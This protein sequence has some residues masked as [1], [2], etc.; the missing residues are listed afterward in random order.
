M[1]SQGK[2]KEQRKV[3]G[4]KTSSAEN[5]NNS[6]ESLPANWIPPLKVVW[7][8]VGFLGPAEVLTVGGFQKKSP[9]L[10]SLSLEGRGRV[11]VNDSFPHHFL[12]YGG[13][14]KIFSFSPHCP[15]VEMVPRL[16]HGFFPQ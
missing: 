11:R 2:Q 5:L 6:R 12:L 10:I 15:Q 1:E 16:L 3:A 14:W 7:T 9:P 13:R 4:G 8:S